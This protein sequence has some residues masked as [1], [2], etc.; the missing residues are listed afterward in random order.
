MPRGSGTAFSLVAIHYADPKLASIL[1]QGIK[2]SLASSLL[3]FGVVREYPH[4]IHGKGDIDSGPIIL[5][6]GLSATG[7][8]ISGARMFGDED[9][10]KR[11]FATVHIFGAPV[12]RGGRQGYISGGA[13][14]NAILFAMFTAPKVKGGVK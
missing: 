2:K 14:G 13:L 6:Y 4:G 1:Y 10:F 9:Y 12:N 7:F 3:G 8:T 11:L 5:G